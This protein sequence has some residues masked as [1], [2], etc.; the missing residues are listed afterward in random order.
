MI[1]SRIKNKFGELDIS[2]EELLESVRQAVATKAERE[3][4]REAKKE[5][6]KAELE[7]RDLEA[8]RQKLAS[9]RGQVSAKVANIKDI[10]VRLSSI[11]N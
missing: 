2:D 9:L 6:L 3:A 1:L 11:T 7:K 8:L 4:A 5:A 10:K